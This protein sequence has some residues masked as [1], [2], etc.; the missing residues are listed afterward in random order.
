M[1]KP[2]TTDTLRETLFETL[3][4]VKDGSIDTDQA[5][6]VGEL[7]TKIID[8]SDLELRYTTLQGRLDEKGVE[9]SPGRI[10]LGQLN[11]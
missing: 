5:K 11:S 10:L 2:L 4:G 7:A 6:A 9:L 1:P 8:V 3:Q